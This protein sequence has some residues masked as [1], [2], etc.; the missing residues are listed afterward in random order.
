VPRRPLRMDLFYE[1]DTPDEDG[2]RNSGS[3]A[4]E[5]SRADMSKRNL[6]DCLAPEQSKKLR[7]EVAESDAA[8]QDVQEEE[9]TAATTFGQ[10]Q[11]RDLLLHDDAQEVSQRKAEKGK[12][13][14]AEFSSS[15][16]EQGETAKVSPPS[17][18]IS[19]RCLQLLLNSDQ[20]E[21]RK[22]GFSS[23]KV[24]GSKEQQRSTRPISSSHCKLHNRDFS[25]CL[26]QHLKSP[27]QPSCHDIRVVLEDVLLHIPE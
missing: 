8:M 5:S 1:V 9:D 12:K 3:H 6:E 27:L 25:D 19:S 21:I 17:S 23:H 11:A 10:T 16:R 14:A 20:D 2:G 24:Y 18:W 22:A 26:L 7:S 15:F 13:R 4:S